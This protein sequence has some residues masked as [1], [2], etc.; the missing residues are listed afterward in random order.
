MNSIPGFMQP[1]ARVAPPAPL[2]P[3]AGGAPQRGD[4]P[5]LAM[6]GQEEI[7]WC[8]SAVTQ[9]VADFLHASA[10]SQEDIA[11][12]H[13][14]SSGKAYTCAPPNRAAVHG[15]TCSGGACSGSCNDPH[16]LRLILAEQ[17]C[18]GATLT[19]N[20]APSFGDIQTEVNAGRPLPCRVQWNGG[21]GH[22]IL[23]SGWDVDGAGTNRVRVLDP[24]A[25][26]GGATVVERSMTYN[27][28]RNYTLS[29]V[30]GAIN[31]SYQVR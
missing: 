4:L 8:W 5:G 24:A 15:G 21:G 10:L 1:M 22:F 20:A 25:N 3:E 19:T 26:Q 13:A 2:D 9:A 11:S 18:F 16:I 17:G 6:I 28:F 7:N 31:Y 14:A 23:V 29:G 27:Q 30:S 12:D